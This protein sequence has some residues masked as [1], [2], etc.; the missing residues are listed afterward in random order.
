MVLWKKLSGNNQARLLV[1]NESFP[2]I[3]HMLFEVFKMT[4]PMKMFCHRKYNYFIIL[5]PFKGQFKVKDLSF[6]SSVVDVGVF[7]FFADQRSD[8][9]TGSEEK[10]AVPAAASRGRRPRPRQL[11]DTTPSIITTKMKE[12]AFHFI[13]ALSVRDRLCRIMRCCCESSSEAGAA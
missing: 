4:H 12:E 1:E 11:R 5:K 3:H 9:T 13:H 7:C 6:C 10:T 2:K 8:V